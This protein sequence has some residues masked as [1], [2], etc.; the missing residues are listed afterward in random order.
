MPS[1]VL[2]PAARK[3]SSGED[4]VWLK[5]KGKTLSISGMAIKI[6]CSLLIR[7]LAVSNGHRFRL[8]LLVICF[9]TLEQKASP[10]ISTAHILMNRITEWL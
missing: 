7:A 1:R 3:K 8:C 10:Q 4:G 6:G 5:G 9:Y 2:V